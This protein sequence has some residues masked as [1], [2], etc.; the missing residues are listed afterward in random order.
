MGAIVFLAAILRVYK[1]GSVAPGISWDEAAVGYNAYTIFHWGRDEWGRLLPLTFK[2]FEDFKNP[3]HVYMTVPFVGFFGLNEFTTRIP[4]ALFGVL[5]VVVVYFLARKVFKSE[6][7]G[8][9]SALTLAI[10]PFNIQ[11]SRFNHELNFA[12][13]FFSL[14][15]L[16]FLHSLEGRKKLLPLAFLSLGVDLFTYQSA[17]VVTPFLV[18]LLII[19]N[20]KKLAKFKEYFYFG[21]TIY[22]LLLSIQFFKPE[23]LGGARLKQN[24]MSEQEITSTYL[25]KKTNNLNLGFVN[26]FYDRYITYFQKQFLFVSGDPI[27]R[28]SAQVVGTFYKIESLFLI[29]GVISLLYGII[30]KR[31]WIYFF[32]LMW[33]LIAPVPAAVS[34][35]FTHAARSM[36]MTISWHMVIGLG[37]TS[38]IN[39][40]K[41]QLLQVAVVLIIISLYLLGLKTYVTYYYGTFTKEYGTE[42]QYGMRDIISTV[43]KNPQFYKVYMTDAFA[44][45]YIFFLYYLKYPLPEFLKSVKYNEGHYRPSNL[46]TGFDRYRF[47][48]WDQIESYPDPNI[49]YVVNPS[50]YDGLRHKD[51]FYILK[52][53][54]YP[55]ERDAFFIINGLL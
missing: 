40:L 39:L 7:V 50:K 9:F 36:F 16:I 49:L 26:V 20:I 3:V 29:I 11:F 18:I 22:L 13:F 46:V 48:E 47:G 41:K 53:I 14:G 32:I 24:L 43:K 28:H 38:I 10:S 8:L 12:V 30:I 34:S 51:S 19:F 45:P 27:P 21:L 4:S 55:N 23:L 52:K 44:Q 37:I 54:M 5:N 31:K 25:Y 42:W 35:G 15:V 33:G 17:K 2:S 6:T 1:L